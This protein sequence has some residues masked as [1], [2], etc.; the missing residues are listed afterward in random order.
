M[1]KMIAGVLSAVLCTTAMLSGSLAPVSKKAADSGGTASKQSRPDDLQGENALTRYLEDGVLSDTDIAALIRRRQVFPCYFGSA[2]KLSGVAV[3][4]VI[5]Y[6]V[7]QITIFVGLDTDFLKMF[8]AV[9]VA[10]FL[11]VPY[12]SKKIAE[13]KK[14]AGKNA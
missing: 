8:S 1:K 13:R 10:A 12:L 4:A 6:L 11:G 7:Y 14:E 3:G 5:Y 2:L 9:V